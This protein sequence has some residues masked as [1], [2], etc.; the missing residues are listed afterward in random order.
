MKKMQVVA[1]LVMV[2]ALFLPMTEGA[3]QSPA[4]PE[5]PRELQP[6]WQAGHER[7]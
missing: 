1:V 3:A 4:L 5:A 7:N 6:L 2:L